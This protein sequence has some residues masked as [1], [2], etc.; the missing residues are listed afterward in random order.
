MSI[1]NINDIICDNNSML[2]CMIILDLIVVKRYINFVNKL[3]NNNTVK[4]NKIYY[5]NWIL[6]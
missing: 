5:K 2:K 1:K 6:I 3:S 4:I